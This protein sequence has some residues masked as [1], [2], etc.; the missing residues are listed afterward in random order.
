MLSPH[1]GVS[2]ERDGSRFRLPFLKSMYKNYQGHEISPESQNCNTLGCKCEISPH[3]T[4][5]LCISGN[6]AS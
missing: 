2:S 3:S 1:H 5:D 4:R 6:G